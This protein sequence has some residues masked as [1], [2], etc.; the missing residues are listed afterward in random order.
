MDHLI[1]LGLLERNPGYGHPLRPEFRLTQIGVPA[2]KLASQINGVS[3]DEDQDLLRR[4]WTL[5]VLATLHRPR[6]FIEIK[7]D[8]PPISD[9]A[10][11]QSLKTMEARH[12]IHRHIDEHMRPPRSQYSAVSTGSKLSE[13]TA[14]A[15]A[16]VS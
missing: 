3:Q 4:S 6:H 16:F 1:N 7:R 8:L 2:A 10:L 12:W 9:R 5:P 15:V 11:S 14:A 13:V